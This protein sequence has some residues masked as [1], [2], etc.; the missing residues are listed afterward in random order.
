MTIK[1]SNGFHLDEN[2]HQ[3]KSGYFR[4]FLTFFRRAKSW[5]RLAFILT[6]AKSDHSSESVLI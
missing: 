1:K 5:P 3:E 4:L 6:S 2:Y